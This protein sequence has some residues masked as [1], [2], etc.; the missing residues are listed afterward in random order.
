VDHRSVVFGDAQHPAADNLKNNRF[1]LQIL[2]FFRLPCLSC[3]ICSV[4]PISFYQL[5]M[6]QNAD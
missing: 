1:S 5:K 2:F 4:L 3:L 6:I